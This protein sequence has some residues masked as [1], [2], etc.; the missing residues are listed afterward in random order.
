MT[1]VGQ[2]PAP[3][4]VR[5]ESAPP[6]HDGDG[7]LPPLTG[8]TWHVD[9]DFLTREDARPRTREWIVG[10][11]PDKNCDNA[12]IER[13]TTHALAAMARVLPHL[14]AGKHKQ[15]TNQRLTPADWD[16]HAGTKES[17]LYGPMS[18]EYWE[19]W[20]SGVTGAARVGG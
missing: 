5:A 18:D 17:L 3:F 20:S 13:A 16:P 10:A 4:M 8:P 9:Y 11:G 19:R 1:Q 6:E 12:Q 15:G 2:I 7:D 14:Q